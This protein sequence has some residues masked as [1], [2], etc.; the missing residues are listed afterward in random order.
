MTAWRGP[1]SLRTGSW[2]ARC[3]S[4][5]ADDALLD[6]ARKVLAVLDDRVAAL[7]EVR[8]RSLNLATALAQFALDAHAGFAHLALEAVA[9]R[10]AAPL[11]ATELGLGL[12]RGRVV[13]DRV[14]DRRDDL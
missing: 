13:R 6:L 4:D 14:V 11:E 2:E 10:R 1:R 3:R 12:T 8:D 5:E 7:F 9:G